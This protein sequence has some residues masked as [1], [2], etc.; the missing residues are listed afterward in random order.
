MTASDTATPGR[1][2]F[3]V[4]A[5]GILDVHHIYFRYMDA[6]GIQVTDNGSVQALTQLDNAFFDNGANL[7]RLLMVT[8]ND[9]AVTLD[10]VQFFDTDSNLSFHVDTAGSTANITIDPYDNTSN[11]TAFGGPA[12]EDDNGGGTVTPGVIIWGSLTPARLRAFEALPVAGGV[13][14]EWETVSEYG[15]VGFAVERAPAGTRDFS[16]VGQVLKKERARIPTMA[17]G[18]NAFFDLPAVG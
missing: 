3:I 13:L 4:A 16:R 12:N 8:N 18:V 1:Y 5:G 10:T 11:S 9:N 6:S 14:L 7:G 17:T 15:V 2:T